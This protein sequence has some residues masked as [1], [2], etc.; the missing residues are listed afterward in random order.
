M[1]TT[2]TSAR[3]SR[4]DADAK[5]FDRHRHRGVGAR[6]QRRPASRAAV[7]CATKKT[8]KD[9]FFNWLSREIEITFNPRTPGAKIA[10]RCPDTQTQPTEVSPD[11]LSAIGGDDGE[12]EG[13]VGTS[14]GRG[15]F[16]LKAFTAEL[17]AAMLSGNDDEATVEGPMLATK[18]VVTT[19]IVED[20][21][22]MMYED[23][24][25]EGDFAYE[26]DSASE[27]PLSGRELALLCI[28]KYGKAHDMAIKHVKM[29][30]GMKRWVSLNLY[31]GH[32]GQRSYP[33]TESE[34]LEQ[35]DVISY[36]IN[37]WGQADYCR[38]FFREKPIARRGLPSRPRVDTCVTLQFSRSPT[39]D[40]ELGDEFFPY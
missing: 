14:L 35:L 38:A 30:S 31:V 11:R 37:S 40:D 23:E 19:E 27:G 28:K 1:S 16:D 20:G 18:T 9:G 13:I 33:Q 32:L 6:A 25:G 36:L 7:V 4:V 15:D 17:E 24:D 29:G 39:W 21:S 34:Y 3:A 8:D 10:G 12:E 5:P 2:Y 26:T 22:V